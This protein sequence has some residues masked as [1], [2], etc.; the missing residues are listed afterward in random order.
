MTRDFVN[1]ERS[2]AMPLTVEP[3]AGGGFHLKLF[4]ESGH[5]ID[6]DVDVEAG[7]GGPHVTF[8]GEGVRVTAKI[9]EASARLLG[10]ALLDAIGEAR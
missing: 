9:A 10:H 7:V 4:G 2:E 1:Q 6:V 8:R 3:K 5:P